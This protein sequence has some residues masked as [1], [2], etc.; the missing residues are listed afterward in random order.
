MDATL[1]R[2]LSQCRARHHALDNEA[3]AT[4]KL[5]EERVSDHENY[6]QC[7]A[8]SVEWLQEAEQQLESLVDLGGDRNAVE[9]RLSA[10]GVRIDI[11]MDL[12]EGHLYELAMFYANGVL[13]R[14][15]W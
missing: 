14:H 7:Y 11:L 12:K 1:N 8:E 13:V 10:I 6:D 9:E 15:I 2:Q 4:Q 3:L 5:L